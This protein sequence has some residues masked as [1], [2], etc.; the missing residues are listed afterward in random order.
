MKDRPLS[1]CLAQAEPRCV[2]PLQVLLVCSFEP[3]TEKDLR[4]ER[5]DLPVVVVTPR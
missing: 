4:A 5:R 1:T 2:P 3:S